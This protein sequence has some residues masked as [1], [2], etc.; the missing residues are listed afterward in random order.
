MNPKETSS[1]QNASENLSEETSKNSREKSDISDIEK[2]KGLDLKTTDGR[3][4]LAEI[5][6]RDRGALVENPLLKDEDDNPIFK[7]GEGGALY[8]TVASYVDY[9]DAYD[10]FSKKEKNF[11]SIEKITKTEIIKDM[12]SGIGHSARHL[13]GDPQNMGCSLGAEVDREQ[14]N[15]VNY[16]FGVSRDLNRIV[17]YFVYRLSGTY[18]GKGNLSENLENK[19][20]ETFVYQDEILKSYSDLFFNL[21]AKKIN[22]QR[23]D[24]KN[25][26]YKEFAVDFGKL[27]HEL[28]EYYYEKYDILDH[29][30]WQTPIDLE[31]FIAF[32]DEYKLWLAKIKDFFE[33]AKKYI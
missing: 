26:D 13:L 5:I 32:C 12:M 9:I 23:T 8:H 2:I 14:A 28:F 25:V 7:S 21:L 33:T 4:A 18:Q 24:Y 31:N 6:I 11:D 17:G 30:K 1:D 10:E 22:N 3:R 15:P 27:A 20:V 29:S 19:I 16:F